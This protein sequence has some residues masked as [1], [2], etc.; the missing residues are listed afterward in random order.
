[1]F[2]KFFP[3]RLKRKLSSYAGLFKIASWVVCLA[4]F[5]LAAIFIFK[6]IVTGFSLL[7]Q[8]FLS[9]LGKQ[10]STL[11]QTN[12]RTNILIMGVGGGSHD[13]PLLTDTIMLLSLRQKDNDVALITIPRDIWVDPLKGK[14]NE[15]YALG[16][17]KK[18]GA[19][20]IL[21]KASV[22]SLFAVPV[23]YGFVIDFKAF[24]QV[25]DLVGGIDVNVENSFADDKYPIAG[26][27]NDN[28]NGDPELKC[29]YE[30]IRFNKG[31]QHL[32]GDTA[33]KFVR[34]RYSQGPEGTDFARSKRQIKVLMALKN[35]I[36]DPK[37]FLNP[38]TISN[39]T[40][41]FKNDTATD[42]TSGQELFL[43]KK[44]INF[45]PSRIRSFNLDTGTDEKPGLLFNPP[46]SSDYDGTW[47]L[48]PRF[49]NWTEVQNKIK[50]FLQI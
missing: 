47:V 45:N 6:P 49:G 17:A 44:F 26:K 37:I 5:F 18:N 40:T 4:L 23:H 1:M 38:K 10:D 31:W 43:A 12:G 46:L 2:A 25:V 19:G 16:E 29:R 11:R 33:L 50:A 39:L 27:E 15:A 8:V 3:S 14:I 20:M 42:L 35:K 21:A 13:G 28:C 7:P 41:N 9:V 32:N 36:T 48:L 34:S 24:A 30:Q 22:S